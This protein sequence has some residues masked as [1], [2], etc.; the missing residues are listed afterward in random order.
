MYECNYAREPL[1]FR[2]LWC[3]ILKKIWLIPASI[4]AGAVIVCSLYYLY[5]TVVTGR[6]YQVENIYYIDFAEDSSGAQYDWVN[7]YTWS[8]LADMDVFID[9][10][11]DELGGT[12]SKEDLREYSDCTVESDGRYL[13]MRITTPSPVLSERVAAAYEKTLFAFCDA[14]KEF[15]AI[16]KE[17]SGE[18]TENSNIRVTEVSIVG[19]CLGLLIVLVVWLIS[20]INDTSIY[21]P[22]TIE[23]RYHIN[24]L[25]CKS[26]PEYYDNVKRTID[27]GSKVAVVYVDS[28]H[29][30]VTF[31]G[32]NTVS[33]E[34]VCIEK[35]HMDEIK[36]LGKCVIALK[37]GGHNGKM[38]ERVLEELGRYDVSILTV[39]L[40]NEDTKLIKRYY[41]G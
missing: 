37:A 15:N 33:F 11:Y 8:T 29:E 3:Q 25:T 20:D 5:K 24:T 32:V 41:K 17:H 18:A 40:T 9:G 35:G 1:D 4:V 2:L 6:T 39:M 14:H 30:E 7:Q 23:K 10:I 38:F 21:I 34:N 13:Y 27:T 26:M 28:N 12:V 36:E 31:E 16:T 22:S 19:A